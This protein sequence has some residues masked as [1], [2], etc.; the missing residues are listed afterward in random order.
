MKH[1]DWEKRL[2]AVTER[3]LRTPC[4]W[5]EDDCLLTVADA[6]EA[7]TGTDHAAD[8]RGKYKSK[9]GAYRLIKKRGYPDLASVL[10]S[11]F[12]GIPPAIAMRG[13]VGIYDSTAGY[14]TEYGFALKADDGLRFIPRTMVDKAFKV[15]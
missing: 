6:I 2:V 13:D 10:G 12:E 15:T 3:H 1:P 5:G 11:L 7:M 4:V 8:I 14:F 9:T